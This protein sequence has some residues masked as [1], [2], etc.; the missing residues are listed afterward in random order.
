MHQSRLHR[1]A[2]PDMTL[3]QLYRL[4]KAC[5]IS[6]T[7]IVFPSTASVKVATTAFSKMQE[8]AKAAS[9]YGWKSVTAQ[10]ITKRSLTRQALDFCCFMRRLRTWDAWQQYIKC[11]LLKKKNEKRAETHAR[12]KLLRHGMFVLRGRPCCQCRT[13]IARVEGGVR[14][15]LLCTWQKVTQARQRLR[16]DMLSATT[17][18][19]KFR[20][21]SAFREWRARTKWAVYARNMICICLNQWSLRTV[22][23]V[24]R[25]WRNHVTYK[26]GKYQR[27]ARAV[28][29]CSRRVLEESIHGWFEVCVS[30]KLAQSHWCVHLNSKLWIAT[31]ACNM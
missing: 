31:C 25:E 17:R 21:G 1:S 28:A 9:F 18:W 10:H 8:K 6:W 4:M 27:V 20:R 11:R 3:S 14:L 29:H 23:Q 16:Q 7:S 24:W 22:T 15:R 30:A 5:W 26:Q 19:K 12:E 2:W 13:A